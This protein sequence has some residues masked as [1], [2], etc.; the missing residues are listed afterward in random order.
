MYRRRSRLEL[1]LEGREGHSLREWISI[2]I[3]SSDSSAFFFLLQLLYA[4]HY[5][6]FPEFFVDVAHEV[7]RGRSFRL[8]WNRNPVPPRFEARH[9]ICEDF[10]PGQQSENQAASQCCAL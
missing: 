2:P 10:L 8:S 4:I 6:P 5:D 7:V 9:S 1:L 3:H